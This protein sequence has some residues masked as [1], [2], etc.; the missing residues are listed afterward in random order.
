MDEQLTMFP[1]TP[2][3]PLCF[4]TCR[5]FHDSPPDYFPCTRHRRCTAHMIGYGTSGL[6]FWTEVTNN[7]VRMFC[8]RYEKEGER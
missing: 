2:E 3:W 5:H 7:T 4:R 1:M 8:K 6:E